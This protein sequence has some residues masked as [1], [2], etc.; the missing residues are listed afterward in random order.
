MTDDDPIKLDALLADRAKLRE[1]HAELRPI[2]DNEWNGPDSPPDQPSE[3]STRLTAEW[4]R[5]REKTSSVPAHD[6]FDR[7]DL[8]A[9]FARW[10]ELLADAAEY[11]S[12]ERYEQVNNIVSHVE[13]ESAHL[14]KLLE[15]DGPGALS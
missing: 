14:A 8:H 2:F 13:A 6:R 5:L 1:V 12:Y 10:S 3:K 15:G 9:L 7:D 11:G 4:E